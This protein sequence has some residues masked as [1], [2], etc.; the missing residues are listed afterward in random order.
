MIN[1]KV[2]EKEKYKNDNQWFKDYMNHI[3]P[4]GSNQSPNYDKMSKCYRAVNM[5]LTDFK[6][7]IK[8]FCN[9]LGDL[10][11][12]MVDDL[13]AAGVQVKLCQTEQAFDPRVPLTLPR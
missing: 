1:L 4:F 2:S 6:D 12:T 3:A 7:S 13:V 10:V 5:D 9:P 8:L 11:D